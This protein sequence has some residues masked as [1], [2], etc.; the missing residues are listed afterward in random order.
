MGH[1]SEGVLRRRYDE[2]MALSSEQQQHYASCLHCQRQFAAIAAD[3]RATAD[4]LAAP[5]PRLDTAAAYRQLQR[6]VSA[7][8]PGALPWYR[9]WIE[10]TVP[11]HQV[12]QRRLVKPVGGLIAAAALVGVLALTP[13][14]SFAQSLL[15]VFQ[16][17]QVAVVR[18]TTTDLQDLRA[19][20]NLSAYG[21]MT[22]HTRVSVSTAANPAA[23]QSATG[24]TVLTPAA[25]PAA[26]PNTATYVVLSP[27]SASFTFS[28]AKARAA[29]TRTGQPLP[30]MPASVDGSTIQATVGPVVASIYG[31]DLTALAALTGEKDGAVRKDIASLR[32]SNALPTLV[33]AQ[34]KLSIVSTG[35]TLSEIENYLLA[36]PGI[37]LQ[38]ASE[39][40]AIGD[41][42]TTLPIPVPGNRTDEQTVQVQ[43]VS[44]VIVGHGATDHAVIWSKGGVVYGVMGTLPQDGLLAV[45]NALH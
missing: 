18:I 10:R 24:M 25:L 15:N 21:T 44:G 31:G 7:A 19:L 8:Q 1:L 23:A 4:L 22:Q 42:T 37:S 6:R 11:M 40:K 30:A 35:A 26:V 34:A 2:P 17:Q 12:N 41:P 43:G 9:R 39:I 13:V 5:T 38:L 27:A 32:H 3:A 16:P 28:A 33:I 14:G 36:Q 20:P 29:A 45:A